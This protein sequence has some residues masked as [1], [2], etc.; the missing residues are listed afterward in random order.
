MAQIRFDGRAVLVTGAGRGLGAAYARALAERGA[1][2]AVHDAGVDPDGSGADA[3]IAEVVA[4]QLPRAIAITTNLET[5]EGCEAAVQT[6]LDAFGQLDGLVSNAG[7]VHFAAIEEVRPEQWELQRTVNL[8]AS[9]WLA[10]AVF[11]HM[12]QRRYGRVVL[13]T[14]VRAMVVDGNEDGLATY[15]AAKLGVVGLMNGLAAE[16]AEHGIRVNTVSPVAATRMFRRR[17]APGELDPEEVAPGVVFLASEACDLNG[18]VLRAS[19]GRFSLARWVFDA[20]FD[21]RD[22]ETVAERLS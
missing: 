16:G 15:T 14:S 9:F 2:V 21:A 8:D 19:G 7:L 22:A 12:K 20:E 6:T 10:R 13:T 5:R 1:L 18:V 4:A 11:P 3:A 17:A